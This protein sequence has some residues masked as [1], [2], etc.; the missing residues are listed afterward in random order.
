MLCIK[1]RT[2]GHKYEDVIPMIRRSSATTS[3]G[4]FSMLDLTSPAHFGQAARYG[5]E[6]SYHR[7]A[8]LLSILR[9]SRTSMSFPQYGHS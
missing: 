9:S 7:W 5:I 6:D 2:C 8:L 4:E 3:H 1:A